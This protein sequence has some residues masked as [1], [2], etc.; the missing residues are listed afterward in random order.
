MTPKTITE[1]PAISGNVAIRLSYIYAAMRATTVSTVKIA[2]DSM[3]PLPVSPRKWSAI[4]KAT[5]GP[6]S[7]NQ[8]IATFLF[9]YA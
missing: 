4:K 1:I 3:N 2:V 8:L 7:I 5:I 6:N 9:I